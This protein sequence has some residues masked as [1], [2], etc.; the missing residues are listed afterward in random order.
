MVYSWLINQSFR[1]N[2]PSDR[3]I[4]PGRLLTRNNQLCR[5]GRREQQPLVSDILRFWQFGLSGPGADLNTPD[6]TADAPS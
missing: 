5:E 2:L 3:A 4:A 6:R 1:R